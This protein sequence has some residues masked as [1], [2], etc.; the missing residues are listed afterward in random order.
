MT[1]VKFVIVDMEGGLVHSTQEPEVVELIVVDADVYREP[2]FD[3]TRE[4]LA[5]YEQCGSCGCVKKVHL[6]GE[7][8]NLWEGR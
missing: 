2:M 3:Y 1:D 8:R 4:D 5:P 6:D 7:G